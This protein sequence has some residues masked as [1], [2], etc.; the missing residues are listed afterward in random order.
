MEKFYRKLIEEIINQG[1]S[2]VEGAMKLRRDLCREFKPN[3]FPSIIK[4]LLHAKQEELP[5]LKFLITKPTRTLSGVTPLAI[6]TSPEKCPHGK[7]LMCPGGPDSHYGDVP[8]SYTGKEP[9]TMRGIRNKFDPY[10]QVFNR[11]EQYSLLNQSSD[12]VEL[13]VMGGTFP[14]RDK[15][16]QEEFVMYAL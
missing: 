11:L 6:M 5:K 1:V 10:L 2:D 4:I 16:Y 9:A 7:C 14:A 13:I 3:V 8:Q 15:E 12:K